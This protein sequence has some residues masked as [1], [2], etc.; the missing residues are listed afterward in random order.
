[1]RLVSHALTWSHYQQTAD[2]VKRSRKQ[3]Q[4]VNTEQYTFSSVRLDRPQPGGGLMINT[5]CKRMTKKS[6]EPSMSCGGFPLN[7]V[8]VKSIQIL[9]QEYIAK[10]KLNMNAKTPALSPP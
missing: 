6:Y 1:M 4:L 7:E 3:P 10:K 9:Y 5:D 2:T 8:T